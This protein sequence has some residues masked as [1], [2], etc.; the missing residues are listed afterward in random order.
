MDRADAQGGEDF[1]SRPLNSPEQGLCGG[2]GG[3]PGCAGGK[4]LLCS[5][6]Q[7]SPMST[8]AGRRRGGENLQS[9]SHLLLL[10]GVSRGR[11]DT[12]EVVGDVCLGLCSPNHLWVQNQETL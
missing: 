4:C 12:H 7:R 1:S 2:A 6:P 10:G 9:K 5:S 3:N 11:T 8:A